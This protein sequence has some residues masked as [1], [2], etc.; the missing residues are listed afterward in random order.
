MYINA[1]NAAQAAL[2]APAVNLGARQHLAS[3][4]KNACRDLRGAELLPA[5]PR[6]QRRLEKMQQA[7]DKL[8]PVR[9][10]PSPEQAQLEER[11]RRAVM[12]G[13][14]HWAALEDVRNGKPIS[15]SQIA[16]LP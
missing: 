13:D 11:V 8:F 16:D 7:W 4:G 3:V 5:P 14:I 15:P 6:I 12:R 2:F 9:P 10:P 1:C